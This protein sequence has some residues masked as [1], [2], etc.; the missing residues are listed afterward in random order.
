MQILCIIPIEI[1]SEDICESFIQKKKE[2]EIKTVISIIT[3]IENT[4]KLEHLNRKKGA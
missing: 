1:A 4:L 2:E 3:C